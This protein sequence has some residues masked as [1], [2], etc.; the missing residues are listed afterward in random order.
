MNSDTPICARRLAKCCP[1]DRGPSNGPAVVAIAAT[2]QLCGPCGW[3]IADQS[4]PQGEDCALADR[5]TAP[6]PKLSR[7]PR[8][9]ILL[10][11]L[12]HRVQS[13][14]ERLL[15]RATSPGPFFCLKAHLISLSGHSS[16]CHCSPWSQSPACRWAQVPL[17]Q[18]AQRGVKPG[19]R[20]GAPPAVVYPPP[21]C[22]PPLQMR[23]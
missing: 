23:P 14:A 5:T 9:G 19:C 18:S 2:S 17:A 7:F 3:E 20:R 22:L 8:G 16:C 10:V 11:R 21:L 4:M 13:T 12:S 1:R 6:A 15:S